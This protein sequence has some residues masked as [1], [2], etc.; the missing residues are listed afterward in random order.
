MMHRGYHEPLVWPS[1]VVIVH[2]KVWRIKVWR[3]IIIQIMLRPSD[4]VIV[5]ANVRHFKILRTKYMKN[6]CVTPKHC[7]RHNGPRVLSLK[8]EL[9]LQLEWIQILFCF[10]EIRP[11]LGKTNFTLGPISKYY[12]P[13]IWRTDVLH[14]NIARGTT[15]PGYW[16]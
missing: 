3:A 2:A 16:V 4:L 12:E 1:N 15:D 5:H 9:S 10:L 8:L 13:N 7:Q 14:Q 11:L 6:G